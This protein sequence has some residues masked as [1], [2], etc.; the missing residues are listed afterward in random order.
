VIIV[1]EPVTAITERVA[2]PEPT[3][4]QAL[5][6]AGFEGWHKR[7]QT[8]ITDAEQLHAVNEYWDAIKAATNK[9]ELRV[10]HSDLKNT[11]VKPL[12][13]NNVDE[14]CRFI[15]FTQESVPESE[16]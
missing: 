2:T 14:L 5:G 7:A 13:K 8:R 3:D 16:G 11:Q 1:E 6:K 10:L 4:E 12:G 9:N 15:V